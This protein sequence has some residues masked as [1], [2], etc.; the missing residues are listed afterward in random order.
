MKKVMLLITVFILSV[1]LIG[2]SSDEKYRELE[3]R[4]SRLEQILGVHGNNSVEDSDEVTNPAGSENGMGDTTSEE[5]NVNNVSPEMSYLIDSMSPEEIA[6]ECEYY[7]I[8]IPNKGETYDEYEDRLKAEPISKNID[9]DVFSYSFIGNDGGQEE[10]G[11]DAIRSISFFNFPMQMNGT[12]GYPTGEY[13][14]SYVNVQLSINNYEKASAVYSILFD[15]LQPYYLNISDKRETTR[16][17]STGNMLLSSGAEFYPGTSF[18]SM[19]KVG[20]M[21]ILSIIHWLELS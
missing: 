21:Y 12:I 17:Y 14:S 5:G 20:D 10:I 18:L 16:W 3:E 1:L 19:E 13:H 11:H 7:I 9:A 6:A 8:N 2:C 15:F 4:I